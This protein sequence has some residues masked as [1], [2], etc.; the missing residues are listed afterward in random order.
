VTRKTS[1]HRLHLQLGGKMVDFSGW[2][3]PIHYGSQLQE[4]TT[5]RN[6]VGMFDVSHM[7]VLEIQGRD[8]EAF[9][10]FVLANDIGL[11]K[12]S[13]KA[14]YS[15]MLNEAGGIIDD[16]IV[17]ANR[18]DFLMVVNCS[19][20]ATDMAWLAQCV[21]G[22]NCQIRERTD[23]SIIAL[24][25]PQALT[26]FQATGSQEQTQ[27]VADLKPFQGAYAGD[28]YLAR[29]GYTGEQGLEI[30]LPH[31]SAVGLWGQLSDNKVAAIGLG[32]RDT[33]RL[34]AGMNLWGNDMDESISPFEANMARTVVM[35]D[36]QF[37]GSAALKAQTEKGVDRQLIGIIMQGKGV[38]RAQYPV[39]QGT[40][41]VGK[42]TSGAFSPTLQR[43]IALARIRSCTGPLS[44]AIRGKQV[45]VDRV[46]LPFAR[47]GRPVYSIM[48]SAS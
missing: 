16:V 37:V 27:R 13:G 5:V 9:L 10:R 26:V 41:V 40:K 11:L 15:A 3:M 30:I 32:A 18:P 12:D 25:G 7:T 8:S 2:H 42:I 4:H 17:Y 6:S 21:A 35:D 39:Y 46:R 33:L 43:G 47:N 31:Q 34:E 45:P 1:L 44:V 22:F 29:T 20:R 48:S 38:L 28:W 36:H 14:M 24:Q 23:L 19:R